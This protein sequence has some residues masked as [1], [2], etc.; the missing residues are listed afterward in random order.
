MARYDFDEEFPDQR[1]EDLDYSDVDEEVREVVRLLNELPFLS[2]VFS[3]QGGEGHWADRVEIVV[4]VRDE[5]CA[6]FSR[7]F[8]HFN[9]G[10]GH[11]LELTIV[12]ENVHGVYFEIAQDYRTPR[13][14]SACLGSMARWLREDLEAL[15]G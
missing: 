15:H 13:E 12:E 5:A 2:T 1:P 11:D 7:W 3:C 4:L 9:P 6:A 10:Y 14:R 8:R